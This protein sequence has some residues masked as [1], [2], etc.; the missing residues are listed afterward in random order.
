MKMSDVR[1]QMSNIRSDGSI[2]PR[3]LCFLLCALAGLLLISCQTPNPSRPTVTSFWP[4]ADTTGVPLN[5]EPQILFSR[6]MDQAATEMSFQITPAI[7]GTFL[8]PHESALVYVVAGDFNSKKSYTIAF[9]AGAQDLNGVAVAEPFAAGFTTADT[10]TYAPQIY[11][12]GRS[13]MQGWFGHWGSNPG[14]HRQFTLHYRELPPLS[15]VV[16]SV[17]ALIDTATGNINSV[18][19]FKLSQTDFRGGN[20]SIAQANIDRNL[21]YVARVYDTV[22]TVGKMRLIV[23]NALPQVSAATDSWLVWNHHRYNELL[24]DFAVRNDSVKI[25]DFYS[26]LA[27]S[28]GA[29]KS[30]YAVSDQDSHLNDEGYYALDTPLFRLLEQNY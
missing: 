1:C 14:Y 24:A 27:D 4:R 19:F 2:L 15:D 16:R 5:A 7:P 8:W 29:L 18:I 21:G 23:G 3:A 25:L 11:M 22:V 26:V 12:M 30:K 20:E 10:G 17:R 9:G 28:K 13:L 6:P